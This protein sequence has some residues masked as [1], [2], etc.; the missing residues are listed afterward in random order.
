VG[1]KA[2]FSYDGLEFT[3]NNFSYL[4]VENS[5]LVR[6]QSPPVNAIPCGHQKDGAGTIYPAIANTQWG[7]IPAKAKGNSAWYSYDGKEF[8]TH[9]FFW[10]VQKWSTV[11]CK[12]HHDPPAGAVA[13]QQNDSTGTVYA[14]IAH[15]Q[16]GEIPAKAKGNTAWFP[17]GEKEYTTNNFSWLKVP[18]YHL[19]A[20]KGTPPANAVA[21]GHQNDGTGPL[22]VAIA[23]TQWGT[24]PAKAKGNTAW[25]SYADIEHTTHSFSW[26][27]HA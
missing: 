10:V 21:A 18:G 13:A 19:E 7:T 20:N 4:E 23:N 3:T 1:N 11:E 2:W 26:V 24:I 8:S 6:A 9:D 22:W 12:S 25:F 15:T 5:S 27:V 17:Y 14:A 16:W